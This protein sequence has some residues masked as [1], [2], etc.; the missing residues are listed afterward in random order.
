[1][2]D[3]YRLLGVATD[4][5]VETIKKSFR[6]LAKRFHPDVNP[7]RQSWAAEQFRIL[8]EA[9]ETL[10]DVAR[11]FIYDRKLDSLQRAR[12][13]PRA[14]LNEAEQILHD[15]LNGNA[16]EAVDAYEAV[17]EQR[18]EF[19]LLQYFS[20]KDYLDCKF[21]LGEEYERQKRYREAL[22]FYE[23]VYHEERQGPRLRYFFEEVRDRIRDIYC[24]NLARSASPAKALEYY[25]KVLACSL[26]R[27]D[28]AYVRK[29]M[30]ER[31]FDLGDVNAAREQLSLAFQLKPNLKGTQKICSKLNWSPEDIR[32]CVS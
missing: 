3:Y 12:W 21:L 31:H 25:K 8:V 26:P 1:M 24:R 6:R 29:K 20:L 11:R 4:A 22:E 19:D 30:A 27:S 10:T 13:A 16:R 14:R 28:Q 17:I 7:H 32:A 15:L 5:S 18:G 2:R 9:Y 23:E